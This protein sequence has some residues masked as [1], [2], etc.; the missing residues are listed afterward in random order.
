MT[1]TLV[2]TEGD[3][4]K[5][6]ESWESLLKT[7]GKHDEV[8]SIPWNAYV[9]FT[10]HEIFKGHI[11][12]NK[13]ALR[14][15]VTGGVLANCPD[16]SNF[17]ALVTRAQDVLTTEF[18]ISIG[19]E[20][21]GR[22]LAYVA[23]ENAY[24][25]LQDYLSSL[26][27]DG[28]PRIDSWLIEYGG[29][30]PGNDGYVGFVGR[31][32]L[33]ACVARAFQPGCKADVVLV[34]EGNQGRGKSTLFYILGGQWYTEASGVLGDKDSKQLI[35]AAWICELPDMSSFSRTNRNAMKAFFSSAVDRYR[36]PY[37]KHTKAVK[38]RCCFGAT[39]NEEEYLG[40][41]TGNRR[42]QPVALGEIDRARLIKD[43]DQLWAE[44]VA[45]YKDAADCEACA[46]LDEVVPGEAARCEAHAWWLKPEQQ[47]VANRHAALR[48][49]RDSWATT[50]Q[51]FAKNPKRA[52][53][54][55]GDVEL[56]TANIL[57]NALQFQLKDIDRPDEM[58]VATIMK[59]LG[60][61][62]DRR[63]QDEPWKKA[64]HKQPK[65]PISTTVYIASLL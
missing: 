60:Y 7:R 26:V 53:H 27:W 62:R 19:R 47:S 61:S 63:G 52:T 5:P 35:S 2:P 30:D 16:P 43:K 13:V 38:R 22:R 39:T 11:R 14:V 32:W 33:L 9:Y 41:P 65:F 55:G 57:V 51:T 23:E 56:T 34:T 40:D 64:D 29:A 1:L 37:D 50:I 31:K 21:V 3:A 25:P 10:H 45:I 42:F 15:E 54:G 20:D 46:A 28:V 12:W 24:D 17:D 6:K 49:E 48:E 44:A 58:R 18:D 4:P 59:K 8:I 36:P